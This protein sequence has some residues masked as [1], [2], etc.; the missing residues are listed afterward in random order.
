MDFNVLKVKG[1]NLSL[2]ILICVQFALLTGIAILLI[3][4]MARGFADI[5]TV[6]SAV[7]LFMLG[8][9]V[10]I[11]LYSSSNDRVMRTILFGQILSF[12]ILSVS[13]IIW[14]IIAGTFNLQWLVSIAKLIMIISYL[15]LTFALFK[16]YADK[17]K[18]L[19]RNVRA[20]VWFIGVG[21]AIIIAYFSIANAGSGNVFNVGIYTFS[22]LFD[23]LILTLVIQL[24]FIYAPTQI[25]YLLSIIFIYSALSFIGDF[26]NL[27]KSVNVFIISIDPSIFYDTMLLFA[28]GAFLIYSLFREVSM[29]TVEEVNKKLDDTRHIMEDIIMQFPLGICIF[30]MNGD[31]VLGNDRF[32]STFNRDRSVIIGKFNIFK[33]IDRINSQALNPVSRVLKG[34]TI[35]IDRAQVLL[36]KDNIRYLSFKIFPTHDS[37][38]SLSSIVAICEDV[39][40][41]VKAE[42]ELKQAKELVELYI[43]LMGHDINNM[44]QIGMGFLEIAL[45]TIN[46]DDKDRMF[47]VKPLDAMKNSSRLID[48]VKKLRRANADDPG[49][50]PVDLVKVMEEVVGE[51]SQA[52]GRE[53]TI[54]NEIGNSAYV[55]ANQ[56]LKDVFL[57]LV[58]NAIKHSRGPIEILIRG[59]LF[60]KNGKKYYRVVVEDDGPGIS[61]ELK[62]I[63]F[64]RLQ[65]GRNKIGG[66]GIGL[67][68]VKTLVEN[69]GGTI[70][71]EDRIPGQRQNGSRFIVILPAADVAGTGQKSPEGT[72]S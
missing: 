61:D 56:L 58:N 68:L 12:I 46:L 35:T 24:I 64:D 55:Y 19:A 34:E 20:L 16:V 62:P 32:F 4:I 67:Y 71:V 11:L 9:P 2:Y 8:I 45:D 51:H 65:R 60:E 50:G 15:P 54:E 69:Y 63:I 52:P 6:A 3:A 36:D 26:L 41:R 31:A 25:R 42:E 39:S 18:K 59:E 22:T 14:Y 29:T 10:L 49:L 23:V 57:N 27:V 5:D 13:G 1:F 48:N 30:S 28:V 53:V 7:L 40:S 47:L 72:P 70:T 43:D 21:S 37:E 38:G 17:V 66:S 33:H 44:N